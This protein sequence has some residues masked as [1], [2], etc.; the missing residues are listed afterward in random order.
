MEKPILTRVSILFSALS[1]E[2]RISIVEVVTAEPKT[3]GQIAQELN[4]QQSSTSQ[5]LA[6]LTRAGVLK[7]TKQGT[8][9]YYGLRG[10]RIPKILEIIEDFCRVHQI[11]GSEDVTSDSVNTEMTI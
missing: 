7:V 2:T 11:Y 1:N 9:R 4:I 10:P 5:H 8:F 6:I 3:V